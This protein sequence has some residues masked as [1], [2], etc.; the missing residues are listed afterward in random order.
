M[1][2]RRTILGWMSLAG[3]SFGSGHARAK[4]MRGNHPYRLSGAEYDDFPDID[5]A[6]WTDEEPDYRFFVGDKI[7]I[8]VGTAPELNRTQTVGPDGRVGMAMIG[9]V[10][11]AHRSIVEIQSDIQ[12]R[13]QRY[14]KNPRVSVFAAEYAPLR[15]LVGG[16]VKNPGWVDMVADMDALSAILAAGGVLHT[17]NERCTVLI[18]RA[19]DGRAMRKIINYDAPLSGHGHTLTPLR[20]LD[21]IYVPRSAV[22]EVNKFVELYVNNLIPGVV[23]NYFSYRLSSGKPIF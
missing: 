17:A 10:M 13:Y 9:Q 3:L 22:G 11:V 1:I 2:D 5:F 20:R 23:S 14:L 6:E 16:E 7:E 19:P 21:I 4:N 8:Q 12:T 18:R 15:V